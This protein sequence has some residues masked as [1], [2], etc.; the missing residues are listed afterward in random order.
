[1][2]ILRLLVYGARAAQVASKMSVRPYISPEEEQKYR[3]QEIIRNQVIRSEPGFKLRLLRNCLD[4]NEYSVFLYF[5]S[6]FT[7]MIAG[8]LWAFYKIVYPD[9]HIFLKTL[10]C[11][12]IYNIV[13]YVL[14]VICQ[15]IEC[16]VRGYIYS[17][18]CKES[19]AITFIVSTVFIVLVYRSNYIKT[20]LNFIDSSL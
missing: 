10:A 8:F 6:W 9:D 19:G 1:M 16:L 7:V 5:I 2:D 13:S 14:L 18:K 17:H 20:I 15:Y 11:L 12:I 4:T 3:E